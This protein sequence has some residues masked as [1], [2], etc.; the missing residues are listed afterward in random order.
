MKETKY[1]YI[2]YNIFDDYFK[3]IFGSLSDFPFVKIFGRAFNANP[4]IEKLF[5]LH[6][7]AKINKI[8]KLPLK[9][10]WFKKMCCHKFESEKA[11]CYVFLGSKYVAED[12][13]FLNYIKKLNPNNKCVMLCFDLL[14]KT[15]IDITQLKEN[16]EKIITYD[17]GESQKYGID[18]LGMDYYTP[19]LDITTPNEFESD[20][21]F[22]GFAKDRLAEIHNTYK[23]LT[24]NNIKCKFIICG[25][26]PKERIDG[27]GLFYQEPISYMENLKNVCNTKCILEIIQ[28]QS[29]APTLRLREAKTYKR[30]LIT[31][32]PNEQ[33]LNSLDESN[34]CVFKDIKEIDIGFVKSKINYDTFDDKYSSPIELIEYLE[35]TL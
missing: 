34:L 11:I 16:I 28:G 29:V 19:L 6:W 18:Y 9:K 26:K 31:N 7:S 21:Y 32:N 10:I 2:F 22:L 3:P 13:G 4:I 1:N 15:D 27:E 5:F 25:T 20:V 17:L 35:E 8:I 23:Y 12:K 14:Q 33:Y 30:K 24:K